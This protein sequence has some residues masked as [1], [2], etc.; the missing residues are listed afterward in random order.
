MAPPIPI[1]A[2]INPT[3]NPKIIFKCS[4]IFIKVF[5]FFLSIAVNKFLK[6]I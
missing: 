4:L 1:G 5:F 3:K 6:K 2:E